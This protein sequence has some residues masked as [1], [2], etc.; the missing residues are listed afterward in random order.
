MLALVGSDHGTIGKVEV[1][2]VKEAVHNQEGV[3]GCWE[4]VGDMD[5]VA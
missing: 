2:E 5:V 3:V 1:L 4:E